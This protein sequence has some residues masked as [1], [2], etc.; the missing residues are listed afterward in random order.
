MIKDAFT[1]EDTTAAADFGGGYPLGNGE[2]GAFILG[3]APTN[4]IR[5][6]H[7]AFYSGRQP[8]DVLQPGAAEAFQR[9]RAAVRRGDLAAVNEEAKG[10]IG[11]KGD[12]GTNLPVGTLS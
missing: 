11:I 4:E 2:I 1:L 7:N 12:Y 3:G 8:S 9:M 10:F 6:T 5:F